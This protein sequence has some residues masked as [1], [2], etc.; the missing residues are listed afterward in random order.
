MNVFTLDLHSHLNEKNIKVEDYWSRVTELKLDVVAITEHAHFDPKSAYEKLEEKKP[1]GVV[2]VPG[3]E[4]NS[5]YGHLLSYGKDAEF[6]ELTDLFE[7]NV[8]LETALD[9]AKDTGILLSISHPWGFNHDSFGYCVGF[10]GLEEIVLNNDIGVEIYNG[11]IGNISNFIFQANWIKK[12]VSFLDFLQK[13]RFTRKTGLGAI[14]N[15]LKSKIDKQRF[16]LVER[17][18]KA[19]ELAEHAKYVTA[20]SDSHAAFRIGEGIMKI[21]TGTQKISNKNVLDEIR[22]KENVI[23]SGPLVV[24]KEPGILER[25]DKPFNRSEIMQGVRYATGSIVKKVRKKAAR[26]KAKKNL[27]TLS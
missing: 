4:L 16:E 11:M 23:W 9:I 8:R 13:N 21:K 27:A 25:A 6:F 12:P 18:T 10:E 1:E 5:E 26:L 22:K 2:L 14:G 17:C 24:E 7:E 15:K 3:S 19:I 20:G